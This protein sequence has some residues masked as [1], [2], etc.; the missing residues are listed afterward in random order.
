MDVALRRHGFHM[1]AVRSARKLIVLRRLPLVLRRLG[2]ISIV[3]TRPRVVIRCRRL[4][5]RN[6]LGSRLLH[7]LG[8][9][10]WLWLLLHLLHL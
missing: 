8:T 6:P 1:K 3:N 4:L 5:F 10:H 9:P 7:L 2:N